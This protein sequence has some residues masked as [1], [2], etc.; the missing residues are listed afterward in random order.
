MGAKAGV[1]TLF[2]FATKFSFAFV[3]TL[4]VNDLQ[5]S[6]LNSSCRK[7]NQPQPVLNIIAYLVD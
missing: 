4:R 5:D 3:Y 6:L 1:N 7:L 2:T